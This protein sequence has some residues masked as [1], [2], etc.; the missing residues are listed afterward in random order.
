MLHAGTQAN[1]KYLKYYE[2]LARNH[3]T[4][5]T[6]QISLQND[7]MTSWKN[8]FV[9]EVNTDPDS[10]LGTYYH[11]N[12]NLNS[13]ILR[14]Q[15]ILEA[16]RIL[17]TRFR[18]GSHSLAIELGRYTIRRVSIGYATVNLPFKQCGIYSRIAR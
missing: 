15:L 2:T 3:H 1:V 4:S 6:C 18:T 9:D 14:P 13:Y 5:H 16:E 12:P 8:K 10:K 17:I 11:I 7:Y